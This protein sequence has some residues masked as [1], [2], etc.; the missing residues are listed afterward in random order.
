M[1]AGLLRLVW[2]RCVDELPAAS[3][4]RYAALDLRLG[5]NPSENLEISITGQNLLDPE[6]PEFYESILL[7]SP[8]EVERNLYAKIVWRF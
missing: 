5:W 1:R 2:V 8:A 3:A 6:H 7:S 4:G